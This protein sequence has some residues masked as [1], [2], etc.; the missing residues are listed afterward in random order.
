MPSLHI[1]KDSPR[2]DCC[3]RAERLPFDKSQ[4]RNF[5]GSSPDGQKPVP[6]KA[7]RV[8]G[9]RAKAIGNIESNRML[10]SSRPLVRSMSVS[11]TSRPSWWLP[12]TTL[13]PSGVKLTTSA[14]ILNSFTNLAPAISQST[15]RSFL[16]S[17]SYRS[18]IACLP[19]GEKSIGAVHPSEFSK[20]WIAFPVC[21]SHR[22]VEHFG[23][24]N[25]A[26]RAESARV[27]SGESATKPVTP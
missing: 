20:L 14:P 9:D 18:M 8:A 24:L 5:V 23:A 11:L 22:F 25:G 21:T 13:R 7:T 15:R 17:E 4:S 27:P 26:T 12:T 10:E 16:S 19:S 6:V 3:P 2:Q 1:A